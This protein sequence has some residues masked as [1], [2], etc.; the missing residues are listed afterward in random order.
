MQGT[1]PAGTFVYP[2]YGTARSRDIAEII[3][4][5]FAKHLER[6]RNLRVIA[7]GESACRVTTARS[8][9]EFSMQ[10]KLAQRYKSHEPRSFVVTNDEA[11]V[12]ITAAR[13]FTRLESLANLRC[14]S[15]EPEAGRA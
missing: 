10:R 13:K 8:N 14:S 15:G 1:K 6:C 2:P 9:I 5:A 3:A 12:T 4:R 7:S 11:A